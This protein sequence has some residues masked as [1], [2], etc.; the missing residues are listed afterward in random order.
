M[1]NKSERN[2]SNSYLFNSSISCNCMGVFKRLQ[3]KVV[4]V[5]KGYD[6]IHLSLS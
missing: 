5:I 2:N 4:N 6:G 3:W 1:N